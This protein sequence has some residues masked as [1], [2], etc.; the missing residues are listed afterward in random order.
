MIIFKIAT[1]RIAKYI[2]FI[3]EARLQLY[4]RFGRHVEIPPKSSRL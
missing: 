4:L 1:K 2:G 3:L